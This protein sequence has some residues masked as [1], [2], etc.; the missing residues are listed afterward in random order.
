MKV[1]NIPSYR[2]NQL[3]QNTRPTF[4]GKTIGPEHH[5]YRGYEV[6][7][8][9]TPNYEGAVVNANTKIYKAAPYEI[10]S[11]EIYKNHDYTL[12]QDLRLSQIQETYNNHNQYWLYDFK[13]FVQNAREENAFLGEHI[14]NTQKEISEHQELVDGLNERVEYAEKDSVKSRYGQ[15]LQKESDIIAYNQGIISQA[16]EA[17]KNAEERQLL[18]EEA[19]TI[20]DEERSIREKLSNRHDDIYGSEEEYTQK[21]DKMVEEGKAEKSNFNKKLEGISKLSESGFDEES[22]EQLKQAE[23]ARYLEKKQKISREIEAI[24]QTIS[25]ITGL[26]EETASLHSRLEVLEK[27]LAECMKK[28]EILYKTKYFHWL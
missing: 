24:K 27:N 7:M 22:I 12:R 6:P 9:A 15:E 21:L 16:Q 23:Y 14:S 26:K 20:L 13:R 3:S 5:M 17:K 11:E 2:N 10:I 4:T 1:L 25:K 18:F 19:D 28:I 8:Y